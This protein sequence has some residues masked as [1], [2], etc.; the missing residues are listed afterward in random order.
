MAT[1][2]PVTE[3]RDTNKF[4][5]KCKKS[6]EPIFVTK[7]G[8]GDIVCMSMELYESMLEK[9]AST[10]YFVILRSKH[11][12]IPRNKSSFV[13]TPLPLTSNSKKSF[14]ND[15]NSSSFIK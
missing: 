14:F 12:S 11:S 4:T 7:N 3:M 5:E 9:I 1:I 6:N 8:Y 2:V 13:I 10:S 15:F